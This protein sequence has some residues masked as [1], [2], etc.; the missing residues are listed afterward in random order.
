MDPLQRRAIVAMPEA[1]PAVPD[2][3]ASPEA[4]V[5]ALYD[6]ISGPAEVHQ[7]RDWDRLRSLFAPRATFR[8]V[9]WL[10][11]DGTDAVLREWDVEQ[12]IDAGKGA[13]R[14]DG[15]WEREVRHRTEVF[16]NIAHVLSTYESR[17]GGP[18][19][20]PVS[21]GVNS[22]QLVRTAGRWWLASTVWDVEAPGNPIPAEL[23]P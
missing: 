15:F 20:E 1:P 11:P 3:V 7:P 8:L 18:D 9:R 5:Q 19:T 21:R 10:R 17:V 6:V 13:W 22:F 4:V 16:G 12:F 14:D 23:L 2:D